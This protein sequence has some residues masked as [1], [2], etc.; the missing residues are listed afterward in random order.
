MYWYNYQLILV[1]CNFIGSK[2]LRAIPTQQMVKYVLILNYK[3]DKNY[4][5]LLYKKKKM[6]NPWI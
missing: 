3:R 2:V 4:C 5:D 1:V 6:W